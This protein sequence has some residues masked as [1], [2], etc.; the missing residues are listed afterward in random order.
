MY[1]HHVYTFQ[2]GMGM[3]IIKESFLSDNG[4]RL[5]MTINQESFA[6][7]DIMWISVTF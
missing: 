3:G 2:Q 1:I 5:I 4:Y 7:T 6:L